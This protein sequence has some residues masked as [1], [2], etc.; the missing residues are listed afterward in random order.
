MTDYKNEIK[1]IKIIL[2][3]FCCIF[4]YMLQTTIQKIERKSESITKEYVSCKNDFIRKFEK[5]DKD[6]REESI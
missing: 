5:I 1:Q 4:L 3:T 6:I 2:F